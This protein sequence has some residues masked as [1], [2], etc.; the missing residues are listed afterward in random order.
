[1]LTWQIDRILRAGPLCAVA[2]LLLPIA[3]ALL[4]NAQSDTENVLGIMLVASGIILIGSIAG[5]TLTSGLG[6]VLFGLGT[7]VAEVPVALMAAVG[8]GLYITLILHDLAGAFHR[9]PRINPTVWRDAAVTTLVL[10]GLTAL[11][12]AVTYTIGGLATW[13]SIVVPFAIA[14]IGFSAK[15]AADAHRTSARQ[16]TARRSPQPDE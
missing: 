1:M 11:A 9:G 6:A 13:Q 12:F 2:T 15:L 5:S 3:L 14:A 8:S 7:L 10:T 16:L 4:V